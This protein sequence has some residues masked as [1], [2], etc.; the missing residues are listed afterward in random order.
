MKSFYVEAMITTDPFIIRESPENENE[1]ENHHVQINAA[2]L[3]PQTNGNFST[4]G[5]AR[6]RDQ[7]TQ[8][9]L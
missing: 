1:N 4:T 6:K 2:F 8:G 7:R 9:F 3:H 5:E